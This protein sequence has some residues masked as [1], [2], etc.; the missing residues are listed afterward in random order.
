MLQRCQSARVSAC[1]AVAGCFPTEL[2]L[3]H[4][5]SVQKKPPTSLFPDGFSDFECGGK[6]LA[7][8]LLII[9]FCLF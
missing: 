3:F 6:L 4:S 9:I 7:C 8:G 1:T 5:P 2:L